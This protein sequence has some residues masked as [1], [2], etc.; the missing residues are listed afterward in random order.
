MFR[1]EKDLDNLE[2]QLRESIRQ[3]ERMGFLATA[4]AMKAVL[5]ELVKANQGPTTSTQSR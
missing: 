5:G 3:T 2:A 4:D 1:T